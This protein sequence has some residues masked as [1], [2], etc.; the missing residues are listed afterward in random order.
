MHALFKTLL[1][2]AATGASFS[3]AGDGGIPAM[4]AHGN[5]VRRFVV[6]QRPCIINIALYNEYF[7]LCGT[8][9]PTSSWRF[10]KY[11]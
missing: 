1:K 4:Q 9:Y 10:E 2:L 11:N 8:S 7:Y 6:R 5:R 3:S